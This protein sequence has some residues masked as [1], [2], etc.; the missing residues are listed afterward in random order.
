MEHLR[1]SETGSF[2][3]KQS[4]NRLAD[5]AIS[6]SGG[7]THELGTRDEF[8]QLLGRVQALRAYANE[9]DSSG[10]VPDFGLPAPA[11]EQLGTPRGRR[12]LQKWTS[13]FT[14]SVQLCEDFAELWDEQTPRVRGS[15]YIETRAY[16]LTVQKLEEKAVSYNEV[17]MRDAEKMLAAITRVLNALIRPLEAA[18]VKE[19]SE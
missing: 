11:T 17:D 14:G 7:E 6:A 18:D 13:A 19:T 16:T 3:K 5:R 2:G 4:E 10:N 12:I 9:E 8:L 15:L 1:G